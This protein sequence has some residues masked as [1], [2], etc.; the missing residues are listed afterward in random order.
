MEKNTTGII[1]IR[2]SLIEPYYITR[3]KYTYTVYETITSE[4]TGKN[5]DVIVGYYSNI[6]SCLKAIAR[7]IRFFRNKYSSIS[8]YLKQWKEQEEKINKLTNIEL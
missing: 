1:T 2:D 6:G 4:E 8:D 7:G 5:Y 3:D